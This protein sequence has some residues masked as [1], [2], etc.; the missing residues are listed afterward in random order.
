MAARTGKE[1]L[2][3]LSR[4]R[5]TVHIQGETLTGSVQDHP[6]F[7]NVVRSYAELYDLQHAPEHKDVLTYPSPT[8]GEPVATSFLTPRTPEDLARRRGAFKI[9]ADHSMG[10]LGRTGDYLNSSLMALAS[11]ADWF[12]QADP[13]FGENI[14]RYYEKVREEDLLC[15][16]T[17]VPPQANRAVAGTGQGGGRLAARIVREDDNGVVVRGARMLATIAPFA[18]EML[19]F[20]S[21]VLRGTPEDKP[22]SYAFAVPNDAKGLRY[23]AR[24]PLDH[25]RPRHDHPLGSRFEESDAVVVFDDVHVPYERCFVLGDPELCNGFYAQTSSVVHM[26]HQVVTRTTAK[27]EY[28]LGLVSLL[29]EAIGIEQFQHVQ[30]DVAEVITTLETLR[31]F[32]RAAEADAEVNEYG[33]LTPAFAP[34]NA[35]RNLY[36]RLY[37]RFPEILRKLGASGLMATPTEADVTGP[38]AADIEAYLQSATLSGADRVKL[39][40]LVWDTCIS[41]FSGRQALYEYYFFGDPVRMAGA[42]VRSYDREPYKV[43]VRAFLDRA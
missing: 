33:V 32:L 26:A 43:R 24:E 29:T 23:I 37:Q 27:T 31:A 1:F 21:T 17:L 20:P 16:H 12:G 4:S 2:D 40:R 36:P 28:I 14:R 42:Y 19:V 39:F 25:D 34:L 9:W 3:R 15:T 41:A 11:A 10:M 7:R 13:A 38:A 8:T 5:P 22:Y 30:Q 35:A 6:A 18:D